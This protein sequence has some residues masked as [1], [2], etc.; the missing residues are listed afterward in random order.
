MQHCTNTS[1]WAPSPTSTSTS[2]LARVKWVCRLYDG[3]CLQFPGFSFF[4]YAILYN[5]VPLVSVQQYGF[6][7]GRTSKLFTV[8]LDQPFRSTGC[9]QATCHWWVKN[10]TSNQNHRPRRRCMK[11]W[12]YTDSIHMQLQF[13]FVAPFHCSSGKTWVAGRSMDDMSEEF[14]IRSRSEWRH[15]LISG[16]FNLAIFYCPI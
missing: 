2:R 1:S 11:F 15:A 4:F 3:T 12:T 10:Q 8:G 7:V 13:R 5:L 9:A 14:S 6:C 16:N